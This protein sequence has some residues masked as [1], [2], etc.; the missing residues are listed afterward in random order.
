MERKSGKSLGDKF[1]LQLDSTKC[2]DH[3][4]RH[5][6][7]S[8][9]SQP[10]ILVGLREKQSTE[11]IWYGLRLSFNRWKERDYSLDQVS[12]FSAVGDSLIVPIIRAEWHYS[13]VMDP[14]SDH[15]QPHWHFL[16]SQGDRPQ[17]QQDNQQPRDFFGEEAE[18]KNFDWSRLHLAMAAGWHKS[19]PHKAEFISNAE[20]CAWIGGLVE[21]SLSQLRYGMQ[22]SGS[23]KKR[24]AIF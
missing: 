11:I 20:V 4:R 8:D 23:S 12:F 7:K 21:Y 17:L 9:G 14:K 18:D 10:W 3:F 15:A 6:D 16:P 24:A 19:L 13:A 5:S 1:V 22:K 2:P